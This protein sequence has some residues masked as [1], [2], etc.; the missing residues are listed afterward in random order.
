[1]VQISVALQN[2]DQFRKMRLLLDATCDLS[3]QLH[4]EDAIAVRPFATDAVAI[5]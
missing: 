3:S 2:A 5:G 4:V 1:M